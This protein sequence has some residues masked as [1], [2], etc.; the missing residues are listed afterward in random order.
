FTSRLFLICSSVR[1]P[2]GACIARCCGCSV[3]RLLIINP[4]GCTAGCGSFLPLSACAKPCAGPPVCRSN[5]AGIGE[6][7]QLAWSRHIAPQGE[8]AYE[9]PVGASELLAVFRD[10][11][12]ARA[13][14]IGTG[15]TGCPHCRP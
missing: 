5:H 4:C 14:G 15:S 10:L 11:F 12:A 9:S 13:P 8:R 2:L 6:R 1:L 3:V 7:L